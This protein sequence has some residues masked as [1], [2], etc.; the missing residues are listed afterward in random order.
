[1]TLAALD[2]LIL[3]M[4]LPARLASRCSWC[5]SEATPL[6]GSRTFLVTVDFFPVGVDGK[7]DCKSAR[8]GLEEEGGYSRQEAEL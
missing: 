5:N 8:F 3:R 1:M 2:D 4:G 7:R 6:V